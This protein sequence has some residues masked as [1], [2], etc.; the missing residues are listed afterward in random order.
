MSIRTSVTNISRKFRSMIFLLVSIMIMS[1][2]SPIGT[3]PVMA[4]SNAVYTKL[5][6]L[7]S[8]YPERSFWN[9]KVTTNSNNG[10]QLRARRD[11]SYASSVTWYPCATHRGTARI[12]QYDCNYFDGGMQC[13]GFAK[14]VFYDIFGQRESSLSRRTDTANLRVGD[15]VRI[16]NNRHSGVVL[17]IS[18]N[19]FTLCECNFEGSGSA[20]NCQIRWGNVTYYKSSI[21]YFKRAT[22]YDSI[23]TVKVSMTWKTPTAS[24]SQTNSTISV[25]PTANISGSFTAAS[26]TLYDSTGKYLASK[27]EKASTRGSYMKVWYN[28]TGELG[29]TLNSGTTYLFRFTT[30]FNG[31]VYYSPL[32]RFTTAKRIIPVSRI[33][34]NRSSVYLMRNKTFQL[35]ASLYP[36]NASN[37]KVVWTSSNKRVATVTSSGKIKGVRRGTC[38][39]TATSSNGKRYTCRVT[40]Y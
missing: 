28:I 3:V 29:K 22:N 11:E 32:Y 40:V 9:H 8:R 7:K 12:G 31:T 18:G 27:T 36:S 38:Y 14:K 37:K 16:N 5:V 20:Y 2:A 19:R 25:V 39:I 26:G 15:Y 1:L 35:K 13:M 21:T 4:D 6:S 24:S 34:L 30:T 23:N 10:D 17:S 33:T